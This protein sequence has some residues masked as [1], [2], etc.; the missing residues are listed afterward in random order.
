MFSWNL[1][2]SC[3]YHAEIFLLLYADDIV[4]FENT[5]QELQINLVILAEYCNRNRLVVNDQMTKILLFQ[6]NCNILIVLPKR[7]ILPKTA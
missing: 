3:I 1:T 2:G 6:C 5:A 7:T 4:I